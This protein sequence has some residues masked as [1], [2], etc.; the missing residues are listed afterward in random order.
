MCTLVAHVGF[1]DMLRFC[2]DRGFLAARVFHDFVAPVAVLRVL[3]SVCRTK[4]WI[5]HGFVHPWDVGRMR[6]G[7]IRIQ[8]AQ[9]CRL[10]RPLVAH[11]GFIGNLCFL[12]GP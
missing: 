3:T 10:M 12:H 7:Q 5:L 6:G 4:C 8:G 1:I 2:M 11:V 9:L